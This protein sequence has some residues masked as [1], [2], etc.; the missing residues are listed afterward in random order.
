DFSYAQN[1]SAGFFCELAS[2]SPKGMGL[3]P[4][5]FYCPEGTAA[6]IPTPLGTFAQR[7]GTVKAALCSPGFYAP[8]IETSECYACPP[9]TT[10]Q[11]DGMSVAVLCPPGTYRGTIE[12]DGIACVP[13]PQGT[14][15]KNWGLRDVTECLLCPPGTVCATDGMT[16][17]C[18]TSDLPKQYT[19]T[20]LNESKEECL[21]KGSAYF[22]GVLLEPWIDEDG[23]GPHFLPHISGQCY[24]N[25]QPFGSPVYRRLSEYFGPLYDIVNDI[26]SQGYGSK[27]QAPGPYYFGL[28]S[29]AIDLTYS[30]AFDL[31][32]NCTRGFF[33]KDAWFPGTCEADLICYS[34]K[35][36]QALICPDG[37]ICDEGTT[38]GT[39]HST[40]CAPGF[41]CGFGTTPDSYLEAPQGQYKELCP[42]SFYCLDG[43]GDGL[44]MRNFCP[45][46][47]FCPTGTV[48]PWLG[49]MAND[50]LSRSLTL[51]D[52]NPFTG[53]LHVEY[54]NEGDI[55]AFSH[56]DLH[57]LKAIDPEL[58]E[59]YNLVNGEVL[60]A[61]I[62][63]DMV[64]ARDN[65][66]RHV[67][68]AINRQECDC[69]H[70]VQLTLDL[71]QFY[72]C[73][74]PC[75][76]TSL[77][78]IIGSTS[79]SGA[80]FP[81][82][83]TKTYTSYT[84]LASDVTALYTKSTR[85]IRKQINDTLYDAY[86][87]VQRIAKYGQ[88]TL[89][90]VNFNPPNSSTILRLDECECQRLLKCPNGTISPVNSENIFQCV[91]TGVILERIDLIP[92]N[93][94]RQLNGTGYT[95]LSGTGAPISNIQ[96]QPLEVAMITIN[97]A[98]MDPN[99]T[100][101]DHYQISVY[102]DCKPCPPNYS[103]TLRTFPPSCT[104][105]NGRNTTGQ[106]LYNECLKEESAEVCDEIPFFCEARNSLNAD[107]TLNTVPG[108]CS[109]ERV[110]MPVFF[111]AN[112]KVL[113]FPD[114]KHGIIQF[115][116]S[117]IS[118]VD[119]TIVVEL[120][121][122][123]Y[124]R[125]FRQVFAS[126]N[127]L[128]DVFT[129]SRAYY[130]PTTPTTNSFFAII[131][132]SDFESLEL[133][134]NLPMSKV[135]IPGST[136]FES[137]M[138]T[139]IFIDRIADVMVGDPA[140]PAFGN[141][142]RISE[143]QAVLGTTP[144]HS[145]E[146]LPTNFF[147]N[148]IVTD[149]IN[150]VSFSSRWWLDTQTG[151]LSAIALPYFPFF[152]ACAGYDSH[153]WISK[154]LE[155]H[156]DCDEVEYNLTRPVDELIWRKMTIPLADSCGLPTTGIEIQCTYEE[157]LAG[158]SDAT[159]W[160]ESDPGTVLFWLTANPIAASDF[161]G[162]Y[163]TSDPI[164][165]GQTDLLMS[166][167]STSDLIAVAGNYITYFHSH[168]ILVGQNSQGYSMVMV[169]T[170][171]LQIN[172]YQ[173]SQGQK[174]IVNGKV[175][176]ADQCV[177]STAPQDVENAAVNGIYPCTTNVVTG[178]LLSTDY[179]LQVTFQALSWY[180]LMNGFQFSI[181]FYVLLFSA[182]GVGMIL[183][184]YV[185]YLINRIFTKM[186]HPPPFRLREFLKAI[187]PQ[188]AAGAAYA[189]IP[190]VGV[191]FVI[192]AWWNVL[193]SKS[194]V[195]N[196]NAASFEDISGDWL[197]ISALDV[198]HIQ[199]YKAGRVGIAITVFGVYM[200]LLGVKY[201]IPDN[202]DEQAEDNIMNQSS[203]QEPTDPFALPIPKEGKEKEEEKDEK[204]ENNYW[205]PLT[206]K[207][208]NF[209]FTALV[210]IGTQMCIVEFSYSAEFTNNCYQY[211]LLYKIMQHFYDGFFEG[212]LGDVL[213]TMPLSML[214]GN[215]EMLITLA[216][217]DFFGFIMGLVVMQSFMIFER[218]YLNPFKE[219]VGN[220][221]P[222]W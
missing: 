130:T 203:L 188:P 65:K 213:L 177:V 121:H 103:C 157:D 154:L 126:E 129:P 180:D 24:Y 93:H 164:Y 109:C 101:N 152:S 178:K 50:A 15:S 183:Q 20:G 76:F 162:N 147:G 128:V 210:T 62:Q 80:I 61:A 211:L 32:R 185:I 97:A 75:T 58:K 112:R 38:D 172:Y 12:D 54:V 26:P 138:E 215:T 187:A 48:Y 144:N 149:D 136:N 198:Q 18:S 204:Q 11:E 174:I 120:F 179:T 107:G 200:L 106:T 108:C 153:M 148:E 194:P 49:I 141:Y 67:Y 37:Y 168:C 115:T 135:R 23:V 116:I 83:P 156:P 161:V 56:H 19:P 98:G 74:L 82:A 123:L 175:D 63:N 137:T 70:Q 167:L 69:V 8:T 113:G 104:Y 43:T 14:W 59:T 78:M 134:L 155:G 143:V 85:L 192:Y 53:N 114:D 2:V 105:P 57:C 197:Y 158:G 30:T 4:P 122:G 5:G 40:P 176:F 189:L 46:N 96:L 13:C 99:M 220:M 217:P 66:W 119:L 118:R 199:M 173:I 64:C 72:T 84:T 51:D 186:R 10:C 6:P 102:K 160:Y 170:V 111:G 9:G 218:L 3:C 34:T 219:Y 165:W 150:D 71:Y 159:R 77:K 17:P 208:A 171:Q 140:F 184:G 216:A 79:S 28:G 81:F 87:A 205:H 35:L 132:E 181:K 88:Q 31:K 21:G 25:P 29:L 166:L 45:P 196:P 125:G 133:P 22:F 92:T 7:N 94:A 139:S 190:I 142:T 33:F 55:R 27:D 209:L 36:T 145:Y 169:Q 146:L 222:K 52:A 89:S 206:W 91:K 207:R 90:Y 73:G 191:T 117:A 212:M 39:S 68:N 95:V 221:M 100:Y 41:V 182:I 16:N 201:A 214:A 1:C 124:Y 131:Q 193:K 110:E 47:Y 42:S 195:L 202:M 44:K 163:S 86:F 60:N 151:G 127:I